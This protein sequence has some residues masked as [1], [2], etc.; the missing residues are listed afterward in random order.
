MAHS[1]CTPRPSKTG[2][3]DL[4]KEVGPDLDQLEVMM[5]DLLETVAMSNIQSPAFASWSSIVIKS[6][7]SAATTITI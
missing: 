4:T 5:T 6:T 7:L 1:I 3:S 2:L